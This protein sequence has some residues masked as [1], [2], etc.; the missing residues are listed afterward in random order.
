MSQEETTASNLRTELSEAM[1]ESHGAP[2]Y[3]EMAEEQAELMKK[4]M[5]RVKSIA[6]NQHSVLEKHDESMQQFNDS[7]HADRNHSFL[8]SLVT[9]C[10]I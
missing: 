8:D 7:L 1:K 5:K 2:V 6:Q 4:N 9:R 3:T 10:C